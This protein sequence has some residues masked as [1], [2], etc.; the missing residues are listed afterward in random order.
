MI[1]GSHQMQGYW[2]EFGPCICPKL[3]TQ[4]GPVL[5][6]ESDLGLIRT[7]LA[8]SRE[9]IEEFWQKAMGSNKLVT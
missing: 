2:Q 1:T 8:D 3:R 7:S 9:A 5:L 4:A 6:P